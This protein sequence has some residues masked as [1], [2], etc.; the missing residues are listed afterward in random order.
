MMNKR[1]SIVAS[2]ADLP[3]TS[4]G[5]AKSRR[6]LRTAVTALLVLMTQSLW[7]AHISEAEALKRAQLFMSQRGK[8][9]E[10]PSRARTMCDAQQGDSQES[11]FYIFNAGGEKGFVIVS[12]DDKT[13]DILGYA[14][15]G[16]IS[17]DSMPDALRYWLDGLSTE[18]AW[19]ADHAG[20]T[21][22]TR[23]MR[24]AAVR[25]AIAPIVK[26]QWNQGAPYNNL[27]PMKGDKRTV[28]GCVAT[29]MAQVMYFYQWPT[30]ETKAIIPGYTKNDVTVEALPVT[31]FDWSNMTTTYTSNST[32]TSADAVAKLMQYCGASIQMRYGP[33]SSSA[34]NVS[35]VEALTTYF[36]YDGSISY[37][38]RQH[39]TY[40]QWIELIYDE[41]A[42]GRPVILGGQYTTGGH[43]FVC[44][45][46]DTDDYFHINWGWG[47][48]SDGFF[49]LSALN[50][51]EQGIGGSSSLDGFS[52]S[53][54]AI[55][56]IRPYNTNA[57]APKLT[58]EK[59]QFNKAGSSNTQVVN[60]TDGKYP[61]NLYFEVCNL[62]LLTTNFKF[63]I[64]L[65]DADGNTLSNLW[66]T[67]DGQEMAFTATLSQSLE[68]LAI[69]PNTAGTYYIKIVSRANDSEPWQDCYESEQL[70]IKAEISGDVM[71]LTAPFVYGT[72][73]LPE[74]VTFDV[75]DNTPTVGYNLP[76]TARIT[77]SSLDYYG[78][79]VLRVDGKNVMGKAVDIPAGETV[80]VTFAYIPSTA[81]DNVLTLWTDKSGGTQ[82]GSGQTISVTASDATSDLDL[83]CT[84]NLSNQDAS[85]KLYGNAMRGT[86]TISNKSTDKKYVGQLNCSVRHWTSTSETVDNVTTTTWSY[87][88][89]GVEH[90]ALEVDKNGI[91]TINIAADDLPADGYYSFRL[92]YYRANGNETVADLIHIGFDETEQHGTLQVSEGYSL[93]DASGTTTIH[94][95]SE[96]IDAGSACFV[97]LS[98][99]S[100]LDG[101]TIT[102]S[103]NPNCLYLLKAGAT[104]PSGLEGKNVVKGTTAE[105]L[106]L[107]DGYDF[108]TPIAFTASSAS[109][110]RTFTLAAGGTSGW[111]SLMLPFAA[112]T[113]SVKT[114]DTDSRTA[115]WFKSATDTGGSFWLR[116]FTG[117][118]AGKVYFDYVD[119][120][121]ANTPY[122]IAVPGD[123]WGEKWKMTG[124]PVTFSATNVNIA[125]TKTEKINGNH[126]KFC[127]STVSTAF[128]NG[129]AL[130]AEGSTFANNS[131]TAAPFSAWFEA[132]SI[133]SL[134]LPAL[135]I[136]SPDT[137]SGIITIGSEP[138]ATHDDGWYT[139]DGRQLS[140]KPTKSGLYI[141]NGKIK[142][143]K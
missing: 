99:L 91:T 69:S 84:Y 22:A 35:I 133:N 97:D 64:V 100:S 75:G 24:T 106:T 126:Y 122:I 115:T 77:G 76:I 119:Q 40:Q 141:N 3:T 81:G 53:Q 28:T 125:A 140:Q 46:Y 90:Y 116:Q 12:G 56:G 2:H 88:S 127:G 70:K 57:A 11:N 120:M 104:T 58:L 39:Y 5:M 73:V 33:N 102:A 95:P 101:V 89:L 31:T 129:Y 43:S 82:I 86:V 87:Q 68:N 18:I 123:N 103:S 143:V 137:P 34:Y 52:F 30:T 94:A 37:A 19:A 59:L 112:T 51:E 93:C 74:S 110:T 48:T 36:G 55:I 9:M 105:T 118:A 111:N 113:V 27:C 62:Q 66:E 85:G 63:A 47:G 109:Y 50:P 16:S 26:T 79:L 23:P 136:G 132:V 7:A 25:S 14:D 41:L 96:T 134:T 13:V 60:L 98:G 42:T 21:A 65:T 80:D 78:N 117:D 142:V 121:A 130:N 32:G 45:G 138:A 67:A 131:A 1:L 54:E 114:S 6:M 108:Y 83:T 38:Q 29:A 49:R 61:I 44:D 10:A 71:T 92:T 107:T 128:T 17:E 135:T 139:L 124:R 20:Q 4:D 72:D 15:Q 8:T